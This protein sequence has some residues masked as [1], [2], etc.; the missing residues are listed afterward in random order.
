MP[1]TE[2]EEM[3]TMNLDAS[4]ERDAH[5]RSG[6]GAGTEFETAQAKQLREEALKH[7]RAA[8]NAAAR[9]ARLTGRAG[10]LDLGAPVAAHAAMDGDAPGVMEMQKR[11]GR[12]ERAL[13]LS[14]ALVDVRRDFSQALLRPQGLKP[15][16]AIG[17]GVAGWLPLLFLNPGPRSGLRGKL[18]DPRWQSLLLVLAGSGLAE[19]ARHVSSRRLTRQA[20]TGVTGGTDL[21]ALSGVPT[22]RP[23]SK[24]GGT[25]SVEKTDEKTESQKSKA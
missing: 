4:A 25:E 21:S 18:S 23:P 8:Q 10:E 15:G 2:P 5:M 14:V 12:N 22:S 11:I 13:A 16:E 17:D 3:R 1:D 7:A 9:Y 19:G 6:E 24:D 20:Q